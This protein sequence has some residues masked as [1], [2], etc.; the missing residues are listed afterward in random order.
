MIEDSKKKRDDFLKKLYKNGSLLKENM[1][2]SKL[3]RI[4]RSKTPKHIN[5]VHNKYETLL[6][7]S[8]SKTPILDPFKSNTPKTQR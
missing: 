8:R 6:P 2:V 4:S 1:S 7:R 5:I 3:N